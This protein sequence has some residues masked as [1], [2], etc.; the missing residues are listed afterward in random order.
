MCISFPGSADDEGGSSQSKSVTSFLSNWPLGFLTDGGSHSVN[1]AVGHSGAT[2]R[3]LGEI[4]KR[5]GSCI[6]WKNSYFLGG[7]SLPVSASC[8]SVLM[9]SHIQY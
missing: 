2:A 9:I 5:D 3:P 4:L 1:S 8:L 6:K 7:G